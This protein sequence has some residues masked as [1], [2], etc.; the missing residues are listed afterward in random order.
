MKCQISQSYCSITAASDSI[1]NRRS[2][3]SSL[4]D[5]HAVNAAKLLTAKVWSE[6][7]VVS[8]EQRVQ[9]ISDVVLVQFAANST[10]CRQAAST[11]RRDHRMAGNRLV[12]FCTLAYFPHTVKASG[13]ISLSRNSDKVFVTLNVC[14]K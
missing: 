7:L 8:S 1:K 12:K 3:F 11:A 2:L 5:T 9:E 14:L 10:T 6:M 4:V 13:D